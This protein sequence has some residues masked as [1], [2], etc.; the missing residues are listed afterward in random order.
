M[1][2]EVSLTRLQEPANCPYCGPDQYSPF[3]Y[4]SSCRS[5]LILFFHLRLGLPS[6]P[7]P[8]GF[9]TKPSI[10]LFPIRATCLAR[11]I[12]DLI[13]HIIFC[14][15]YYLSSTLCTFLHSLFP[16]PSYAQIFSSAPYSEITY[17][18]SVEEIIANI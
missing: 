17:R 14:E 4:P 9:L 6:C 11:L 12:F 10:Y 2:P 13:T 16:R 7:Y 5:N 8:S 15:E 3:S 18:C 1:E